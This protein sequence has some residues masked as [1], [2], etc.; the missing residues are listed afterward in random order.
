MFPGLPETFITASAPARCQS[1]LTRSPHCP[2]P[3]L[4]QCS[5]LPTHSPHCP[6]LPTHSPALLPTLPP[7][8][9][10][11]HAAC[12]RL[13]MP[14]IPD[15]QPST[16]PGGGRSLQ[17][18]KLL[19]NPFSPRMQPAKEPPRPAM[20]PIR[21]VPMIKH[22]AENWGE[23]ERFQA[24]P[25]DLLISTYPKSGT[26]WISE[27]IDMIYNDGDI[28]KCK[29][30][31]IY[32]RVPFL[33]FAVPDIP[34]GVELLQKR[35]S[36]RLVKTHLPVQLLP[37]SFWEKDCKMIYMARN[38]KD[39]AVS[40]YYFYQM[41]K[42]HPDP[43]PWDKFLDDFMAGEV[44]F[45]SWYQHVRGWWDKRKEQRMLYLFYED[46]KEDPR[47]EIRKVLEFL[48]RPLSEEL[49]EA[50]A[51]HTTFAEMQQNFMA[52]YR[53]IPTNVMDH[54]I[55]PFMR[56]GVTGDWKTQFTVAQNERFDANYER[57]M[58]GTDLCFRL[59]I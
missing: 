30:D 49:V 17:N 20:I 35:S 25:D 28:E 37:P 18:A 14:L 43:G 6:S 45:G 53:T 12:P 39:V 38:P 10:A 26:T 33:E 48:G 54:S 36:Q 15:P 31:P 5:S 40:Y 13:L 59:E 57:Q 9:G 23:V 47:R 52:N 8:A 7:S 22:F 3:Q 19:F 29:Q 51:R 41:A 44:T 55:S 42:V 21:G 46:M 32:M 50:I 16:S 4:R 24:Q 1:L 2:A 11:P 58:E 27:I 56:K 34:T